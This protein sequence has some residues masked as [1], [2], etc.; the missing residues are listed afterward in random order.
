MRPPS[1][2]QH[3]LSFGEYEA[4]ITGIGASLRRL[5]YRG[6]DLVL[7]FEVDSIRPAYSGAIL[8]PWPNRVIDG[9]YEWDG[10]NYQLPINEVDRQHALHGLVV[11]LEFTPTRRTTNLLQLIGIIEP[12]DGYPFRVELRITYRLDEAGLR[13]SVAATNLGNRPAPYG[14]GPHPYL[15]AGDGVV[16]DWVLELAADEVLTVTEDRLIPL[17]RVAVTSSELDFRAGRA[18]ASTVID[19]AYTSLARDQQSRATA[20]LTGPNGTGVGMA[21]GPECGWVQIHTADGSDRAG[22]AVEPMTCPPAAF[23]TGIDLQSLTPGSTHRAEWT[24]FA[25]E[26]Y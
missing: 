9:L 5:T 11:W 8:A 26:R 18:I 10:G 21:W 2:D 19:H 16:D 4:T 22:L 15:V 1:G 12:Q 6:R 7:P 17:D 14:V 25:V 24:I 3:E 23:N 20:R 13:T